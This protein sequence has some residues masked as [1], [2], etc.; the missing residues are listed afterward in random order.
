MS[1]ASSSRTSHTHRVL[2][3]SAGV[4]ELAATAPAMVPHSSS[5]AGELTPR[6]SA[7]RF[8]KRAYSEK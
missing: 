5:D 4:T 6:S 7:K 8:F 2:I 1:R 3:T